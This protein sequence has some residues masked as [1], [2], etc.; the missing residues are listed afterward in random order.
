MAQ[1]QG[2]PERHARGPRR[3]RRPVRIKATLHAHGTRRRVEITDYS[4]HGVRL[5]RASGIEPQ[6][7]VTVEL[8]SGLRVPM[9]VLWVGASSAGLR[10]LGPITHGHTV[11]RSLDEAAR[12]YKLRRAS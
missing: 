7:R 10:F 6:E 8:P 5:E 3:P 4:Q 2:S 9:M 1:N 12:R 11:M